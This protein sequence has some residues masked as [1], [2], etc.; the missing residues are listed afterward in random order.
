MNTALKNDLKALDVTPYGDNWVCVIDADQL[1][2]TGYPVTD[3]AA[4]VTA[5]LRR[6][7]WASL[8]N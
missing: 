1:E 4:A 5:R 6:S 2:V 7:S 8:S 3:E